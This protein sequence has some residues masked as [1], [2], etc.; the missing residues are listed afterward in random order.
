MSGCGQREVPH[1]DNLRVLRCAHPPGQPVRLWVCDRLV[2][3]VSDEEDN[4][5]MSKVRRVLHVVYSKEK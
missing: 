1:R 3:K 5:V 4:G 2:S